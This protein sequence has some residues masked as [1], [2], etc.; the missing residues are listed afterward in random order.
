D[1]LLQEFTDVFLDEVPHGLPPLRGIEHQ[2][3]LI[4]SCP[5]PNKPPYRTNPEETKEIQKQVEFVKELHVKVRANIETS[6]EQYARQANKGI[7][8]NAYKLD[9]PT[10]YG[11][12]FDS[13]MNPFEEGGG[14]DRDPTN[15]AKDN[16]CDAGDPHDQAQN[17]N[18][19][20]IFA[21]PEFGNYGKFKAK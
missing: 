15:K 5:I 9:L 1:S 7:N 21:R 6:N 14:D 13:R 17:Q 19:E 20:A 2:I 3:N 18:N 4:P 12:E 10:A 16:L 11:E 8:D